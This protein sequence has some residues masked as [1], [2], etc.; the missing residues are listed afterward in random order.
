MKPHKKAENP[1]H[2]ECLENGIMHINIKLNDINFIGAL[3]KASVPLLCWQLQNL[4]FIQENNKL[5]YLKEIVVE[6]IS[7]D[8]K[9]D[10]F[11]KVTI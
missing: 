11:Q 2:I 8:S 6:S 9:S 7:Y 3:V 5:L 10:V 4:V 1:D